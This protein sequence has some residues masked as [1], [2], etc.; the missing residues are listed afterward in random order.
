MKQI[1]LRIP[2]GLYEQAERLARQTK[3]SRSGLFADA[4]REYQAHHAPDE[5]TEAMNRACAEIGEPKSPFIASS[6]RR[7]LEQS[8]W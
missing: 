8:E 1:V 6:A 4:L 2:N 3:K 5:V 7:T